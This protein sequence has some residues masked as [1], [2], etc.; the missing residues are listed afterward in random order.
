MRVKKSLVAAALASAMVVGIAGTASAQAAPAAAGVPAPAA[1]A[2][3]GYSDGDVVSLLVFG[4]GKAAADHPALAKQIRQRRGADSSL[5]EEQL[6]YLMQK[7][8]K[9]DPTFHAKV[10]GAVQAKDPFVVQKGMEQLNVDLKKYM[11]EDS[12]PRAQNAADIAR[13]NGWVWTKAN[14]LTVAN[15]VAA[16]NVAGATNVMGAAEAVFVV[17]ITPPAAS[18]GFD[19]EQPDQLD[20]NNLVASVADAL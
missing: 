5:T 7:L 13:P 1:V 15:A 17:V 8:H 4:Q 14:I 2:S 16:I 11:A 3:Q 6:S 9:V 18:Y 19:L 12:G 10:T 20:E